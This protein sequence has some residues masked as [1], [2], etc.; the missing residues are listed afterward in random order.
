MTP[1]INLIGLI[2]DDLAASLAFYR[3]LGVTVPEDADHLPHAETE[4]PGG[5]RLAWDTLE[6]VRTFAPDYQPNPEGTRISLAFLC[7]SP[8]EVDA[9]YRELVEAGH[10]GE[11]EPWDAHWGQR[12]AVVRDP[13]GN[14]I[15]LFAWQ[16]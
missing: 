9:L 10:P 12:Y 5:I 15:D 8:A 4:L 7:D 13:D 6:S 1:R 2:T 16:H 3:R 11:K 14:S